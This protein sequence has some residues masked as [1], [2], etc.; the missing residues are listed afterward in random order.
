[1]FLPEI[2]KMLTHDS[3]NPKKRKKKNETMYQ[4]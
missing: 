3:S 4:V 2:Y 1:M